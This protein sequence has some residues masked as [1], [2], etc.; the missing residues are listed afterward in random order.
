VI[1]EDAKGGAG[2]GK[3]KTMA[4]YVWLMRASEVGGQT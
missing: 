4:Q 2:I 3:E 1:A